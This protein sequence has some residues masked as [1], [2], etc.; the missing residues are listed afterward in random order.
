MFSFSF[1]FFLHTNFPHFRAAGLN[2]PYVNMQKIKK[3]I[4]SLLLL[5]LATKSNENDQM[6]ERERGSSSNSTDNENYNK[7]KCELGCIYI[8][9]TNDFNSG[10]TKAAFN[11][12]NKVNYDPASALCSP[13][14][15]RYICIA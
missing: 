1:S 9:K 7:L 8:R 10:K 5:I 15:M 4:N 2:N 12:R 3:F 14:K 13:H 11:N 6:E